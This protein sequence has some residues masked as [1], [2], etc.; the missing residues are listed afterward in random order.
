MVGGGFSKLL[1]LLLLLLFLLLLLL[2]RLLRL[3]LLRNHR[4]IAYRGPIR[5]SVGVFLG[6]LPR[7]TLM[8]TLSSGKASNAPKGWTYRRKELGRNRPGDHSSC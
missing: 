5:D 4:I 1:L 6:S 8:Q 2:G 7:F 3:Q